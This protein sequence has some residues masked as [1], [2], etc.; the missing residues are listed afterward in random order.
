M[1]R[2]GAVMAMVI[3]GGGSLLLEV[4]EKM[5]LRASCPA[6][7]TSMSLSYLARHPPVG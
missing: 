7:P 5:L 2:G 4:E 6:A 1:S 3:V